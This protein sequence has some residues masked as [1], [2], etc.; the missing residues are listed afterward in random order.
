MRLGNSNAH[1]FIL[2]EP[3]E[4]PLVHKKAQ[5]CCINVLTWDAE[6]GDDV[7]CGAAALPG[8][9]YCEEC[10]EQVNNFN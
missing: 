5:Q 3:I 1:F 8:E 9:M 4:I 2:Q 10:L 6:T 7:T